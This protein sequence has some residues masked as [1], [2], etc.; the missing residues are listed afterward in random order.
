MTQVSYKDIVVLGDEQVDIVLDMKIASS[1]N[2]TSPPRLQFNTDKGSLVFTCGALHQELAE[3]FGF[4]VYSTVRITSEGNTQATLIFDAI[5]GDIKGIIV[6]SKLGAVR[7]GAI[8]GAT[9]RI[10]A[11]EDSSVVGVLGSGIQTEIQLMACLAVR[12]V[13]HVKV[14]S[15]NAGHRETFVRKFQPLYETT[16]QAVNSAKECVEGVDILLVA[17]NSDSQ[18]L[19]PNGC[20]Q[21][22]AYAKRHFIHQYPPAVVPKDLSQIVGEESLQQLKAPQDIT[23]FCTVGLA[24]TQPECN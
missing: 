12:T 2:L 19:K 22:D 24:G 1:G 3:T 11:K 20:H 7:T 18:S 17:T 15:P 9:I 8:G 4:R 10:L 14:Y 5:T 6:G 16:F 13:K 23:L 21:I